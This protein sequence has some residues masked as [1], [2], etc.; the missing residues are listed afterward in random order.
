MIRVLRA[1]ASERLGG[2]AIGKGT[3]RPYIRHHDFARW[4]EDFRALGHEMHARE[5]DEISARSTRRS[6]KLQAVTD[7]V[8]DILDIRL[9]VVVS[10]KHGVFELLKP[11]DFLKKISGKTHCRSLFSNL[12]FIVQ[13]TLSCYITL[14]R[15]SFF[16]KGRLN[17]CL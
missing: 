6:R 14:H 10:E 9:L 7:E 13:N 4:V 5:K 3:A 15:L 12:S 16:E 1:E 11:F 2:A 17:R 8:R